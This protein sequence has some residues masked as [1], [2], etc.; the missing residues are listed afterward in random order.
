MNK[1]SALILV[2]LQNDFMPGGALEVKSGDQI[3]PVVNMLC[4]CPFD[5]IIATKDWH[6]VNH[7]SFAENHNKKPGEHITTCG[8]DQILWSTHCVQHTRG[9]EFHPGWSSEKVDRVVQKGTDPL[10]DS[11]STFFDNGHQKKTGLHDF[12]QEENIHYLYIAGLATDYCV[13]YSALDAK[14]LGYHVVVIKDAC[15]AVNLKAEDETNAFEEM[16]RAGIEIIH[17]KDVLECLKK[18]TRA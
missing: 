12:L 2:D 7:M 9:A 3:L 15:R 13:K 4:D 8:V 10:I 6:P 14:H 17:S 1:K 5:R 18:L 11:Y 16:R